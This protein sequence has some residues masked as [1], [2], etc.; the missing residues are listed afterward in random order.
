MLV[1][2]KEL[3]GELFQVEI[4][5][6]ASVGDLKKKVAEA[7][8]DSPADQ[9]KL[10]YQGKILKDEC[11]I[12]DAG[13]T[14]AGG[15]FVVCMVTRPVSTAA[16]STTEPAAASAIAGAAPA[17]AAAPPVAAPPAAAPGPA[18]TANLPAVITD[19]RQ[20]PRWPE[21][22]RQ[23]VADPQSL[24]RMLRALQMRWP[25]LLRALTENIQ[26]FVLMCREEVGG[27]PAGGM[28]G[29]MPPGMQQIAAALAQNPQVLQQM[30]A[31]DPELAAALQQNPQAVIQAL[32]MAAAQGGMGG[33]M[34][35]GGML[36]G[37]GGGPQMQ[38]DLSEADHAAVERLCALGYDRAMVTE[39]YVGC[40]RNEELAANILMDEAMDD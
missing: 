5:E 26:G 18:P 30:A 2:L 28:P 33:G 23:V 16:A 4:D 40:G 31:R 22:A 39:V 37:G 19:L 38:I 21:L 1:T 10:I 17:P 11:T 13:I 3:K 20:N 14:S 7:R 24:P 12:K 25:Q 34:G 32:A 35:G 15:S 9:Q 36:G 27:G 29:G 8:A 6:S